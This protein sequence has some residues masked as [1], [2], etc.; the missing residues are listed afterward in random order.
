VMVEVEESMY[1][2]VV[3]LSLALSWHWRLCSRR[4]ADPCHFRLELIINART[5]TNI[6]KF[7][8]L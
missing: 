4:R 3:G 7:Y 6:F 2:V 1:L 8:I 5:N